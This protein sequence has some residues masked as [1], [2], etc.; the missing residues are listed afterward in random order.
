MKK[1]L[2]IALAAFAG[3]GIS[4]PAAASAYVHQANAETACAN[5]NWAQ[6]NSNFASISSGY[7]ANLWENYDGRTGNQSDFMSPANRT[8]DHR[9]TVSIL[10][11]SNFAIWGGTS[12]ALGEAYRCTVDSSNGLDSGIYL[13]ALT[14]YGLGW[15]N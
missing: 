14:D 3:I 12:R 1:Y 15:Q 5:A 11:Q 6:A 9:I 8:N 7:Y 2:V 10:V 13:A 4:V